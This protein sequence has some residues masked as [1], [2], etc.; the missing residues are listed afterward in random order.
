MSYV[1]HNRRTLLCQAF[2]NGSTWNSGE[3]VRQDLLLAAIHRRL[4]R[5][6]RLERRRLDALIFG[7]SPVLGL[8]PGRA[9]RRRARARR[10]VLH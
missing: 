9:A 4:E 10:V 2:L 3:I 1:N 6:T 7:S 8:R 5:G